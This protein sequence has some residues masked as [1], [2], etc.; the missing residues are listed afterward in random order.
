[1]PRLFIT[2]RELDFVSDI[3]K[4]LM[5]DVIGQKIYYYAIRTDATA[6]NKLYQE[7]IAKVFDNPIEI[8][9]LTDWQ[10]EETKTNKWGSEKYASIEIRLHARDLN[11]KNITIKTGDYFSYGSVFFEMTSVST[12]SKIFGQVE[13]ITGYKI[14]GKQAREGLVK[15]TPLGPYQ[16]AFKLEKNVQEEFTQQRGE[17]KDAFNEVTG[18]IRELKR[19]EK[20]EN[21]SGNKTIRKDVESSFY[22]DE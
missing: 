15:K 19:K 13:H 10:P 20:I 4:E 7:A 21:I 22:G 9:C 1:M 16:E 3:T 5:K 17:Q 11:D 2:E 8:N 6:E 12:I 18:D 14:S